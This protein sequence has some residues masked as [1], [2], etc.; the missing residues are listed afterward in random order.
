[1]ELGLYTDSL[2]HLARPAAL[3]VA[4]A[5]GATAIEIATGGQSAAP[6]LDRGLLL[7]SAAA[8]DQ[9]MS[10]LNDR[11]LHL[12]ALN[13]SAWLLHPRRAAEQRAI[14]EE[15]FGLAE[16]LGVG[17]IVTMSGCPGD[18]STASTVNWPVYPWPDDLVD[19]RRRQ[20]DDMIRLWQ[21]LAR[22]ATDHGVRVALEL[23]PLQLVYNV[24]TLLELRATVGDVVGA[25]LDPSHLFWQQMDPLAV[26]GAL[27]PAIHHVHLKDTAMVPEQLAVA[28]VLDV[29]SFADPTGRAWNFRTVGRGHDRTFWRAFVTA[30]VGVGYTGSLSIEHE[31]RSEAPLVGVTESAAFARDLL[32][33]DS[34]RT[35]GGDGRSASGSESP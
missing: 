15:T 27:G 30:L 22:E 20:W 21:D 5:I 25:N 10:E 26:I 34:A 29:R 32:P 8:R 14:V 28:G 17:T 24:P 7:G 13:C 11:G 23:H 35:S 1:M 4:A 6:H 12:A 19:L 31:D 33:R 2:A 18:G 9:L 3:D 16:M